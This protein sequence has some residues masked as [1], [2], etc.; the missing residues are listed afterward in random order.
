MTK[1]STEEQK[2]TSWSDYD[3]WTAQVKLDNERLMAQREENIS[4]MDLVLHTIDELKAS[5]TPD[6][7]VL[8]RIGSLID[9]D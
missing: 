3:A 1:L 5:D 2:F 8:E 6:E 4:R 7:E 9:E